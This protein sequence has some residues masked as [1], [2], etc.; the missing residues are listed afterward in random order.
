MLLERELR[1]RAWGWQGCPGLALQPLQLGLGT[2]LG[3]ESPWLTVA[4]WEMKTLG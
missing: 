4:S 3:H 1:A 2:H